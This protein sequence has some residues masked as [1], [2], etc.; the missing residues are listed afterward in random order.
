VCQERER[1]CSALLA[2]REEAF[3]EW[4]VAETLH[5][6]RVAW[7]R[8]G[9]RVTLHRDGRGYYAQIDRLRRRTN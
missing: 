6:V 4:A 3:E 2:M 7:G 9:D 1:R 8:L 5:E